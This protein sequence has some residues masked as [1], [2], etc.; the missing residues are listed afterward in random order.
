[1]AGV[2]E[3]EYVERTIERS[4]QAGKLADRPFAHSEI[5]SWNA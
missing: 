1:M 2:S 5:A 4:R 3:Y